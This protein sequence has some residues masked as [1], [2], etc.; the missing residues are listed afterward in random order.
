MTIFAETSADLNQVYSGSQSKSQT[1]TITFIGRP[2]E[3]PS[4]KNKA[5]QEHRKAAAEV[6]TE[7]SL[8]VTTSF[9]KGEQSCAS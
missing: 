6:E 5:L 1:G 9:S 7:C 3:L 2:S 8:D 4:Q